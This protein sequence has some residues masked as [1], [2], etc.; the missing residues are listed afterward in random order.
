M[1]GS[2]R[3]EQIALQGLHDQPIVKLRMR[4]VVDAEGIIREVGLRGGD[5]VVPKHEADVL[6]GHAA[7]CR[8]CRRGFGEGREAAGR[9]SPIWAPRACSIRLIASLS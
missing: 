9:G 8:V 6:D 1:A 3:F 4:A 2:P 7:R 5:V